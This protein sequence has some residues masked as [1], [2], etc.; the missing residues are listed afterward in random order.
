MK[1]EAR[2]LF[3]I[4]CIL[5]GLAALGIAG[6]MFACNE[7]LELEAQAVSEAVL[8]KLIPAANLAQEAP[9]GESVIEIDGRPYLGVLT[10]PSLGIQLPLLAECSEENLK[11]G[12]CRFQGTVA[13]NNIMI[14]GHNYRRQ[15]SPIKHMERGDTIEY[16]DVTGAVVVWQVEK[17]ELVGG[18]DLEKMESGDWDMT[19]FTCNLGGKSRVTLRCLRSS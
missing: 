3:G 15:L 14:A 10:I 7:R 8:P 4:G 1:Q 11:L 19:L 2:K 16:R 18:T 12:P 9:A 13:D 6:S 17:T 5:L